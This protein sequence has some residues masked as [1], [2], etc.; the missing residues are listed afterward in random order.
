MRKKDEEFYHEPH[1]PTRT[2]TGYEIKVR[3]VSV[4]CGYS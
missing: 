3:G 1:E 4:V 2:T